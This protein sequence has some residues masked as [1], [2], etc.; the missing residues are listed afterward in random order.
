MLKPN[1][2][3]PEEEEREELEE[4][5]ELEEWAGREVQE[6]DAQKGEARDEVQYLHQREQFSWT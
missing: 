4:G 3:P 5:G 2:A 6:G 1:Y